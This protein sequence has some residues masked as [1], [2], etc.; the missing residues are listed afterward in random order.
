MRTYYAVK[1]DRNTGK[2]ELIE[3]IEAK[4]LKE[5]RVAIARKNTD[6]IADMLNTALAVVGRDGYREHYMAKCEGGTKC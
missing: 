1:I 4:S 5:A 6:I 3:T 2:H